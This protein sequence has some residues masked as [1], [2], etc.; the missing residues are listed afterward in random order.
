MFVT[1][2]ELKQ[3]IDGREEFFFKDQPEGFTVFNYMVNFQD[4]FP[5]IQTR[6]DALRRECRGTK[7]DTKT[8]KLLVLPYHKFFNLGEKPETRVENVDWNRN[9]VILEKLDGSMIHSFVLNGEIFWTTKMG[10]NDIANQAKHFAEQNGYATFARDMDAQN[11]SPMYEWCS[12]KNRIVVDYPEDMLVLTALRCRD[13]GEYVKYDRM[14][15]MATMYNIPVVQAWSMNF[16]DGKDLSEQVKTMSGVE[17]IILRF[18]DGMML[19]IK[20]D[21]YLSL[22]KVKS[23]MVFEKDVLRLILDDKIDDAK[24]ALTVEEQAQLDAF[25]HEV[26]E[27]LRNTA[28][29]LSWKVIEAQDNLNGSKKRFALEVVEHLDPVFKGLAFQIWDG[30]DPMEAVTRMAKDHTSSQT[31]VNRARPLWGEAQWLGVNIEE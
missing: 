19:K 23:N 22:H 31:K 11:I 2:D 29:Y 12:R 18:D 30:V 8:G 16:A 3:A 15:E 7:F 14:V 13:T 21:E 1:M 20:G 6:S 27:G 10:V 26:W 24:A 25:H 17:G 28:D 9:H 4:T 5:E